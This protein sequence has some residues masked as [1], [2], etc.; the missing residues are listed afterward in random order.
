MVGLTH[1]TGAKIA[2]EKLVEFDYPLEKINLI[3]KCILNH[4]GSQQNHRDSIE[5]QIIAEADTMSAFDNISGI[6]KAAFVYE[7]ETQGKAKESVRRKLKNKWNQLH[8]K[9]S[10]EIIKPKYDAAMLLLK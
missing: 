1:I 3:K 10:K 7:D 5:E 4:R 2:E 8:F 6:F 9:R